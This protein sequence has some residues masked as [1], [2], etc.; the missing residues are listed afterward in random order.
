MYLKRLSDAVRDG[1]PIRGVIRGTAVNANGKTSGITQPSAIGQEAAARAAYEFAGNLSTDD[2]SY[3]ECHG[4]GTPV[5][6]PIELNG[7]TNLFLKN[8][9]RDSLLV[10]AV[11]TN[12]GHA[13]AASAMA[14]VMKVVLAMETGVI[15]ATIG[16][17]NF[18]PKSKAD[19]STD[20]HFIP[21]LTLL[22]DS[23]S[24]FPMVVCRLQQTQRNGLPDTVS[25]V[26][27]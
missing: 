22:T 6:D 9:K 10:G 21:C 8:S 3:F 15:P 27:A 23:Q 2:T 13:E 16:I 25:D 14:S 19:L 18:N 12:V 5:G 11:K 4:T 20:L 7:I 1:D 26:R 24:T 17:K